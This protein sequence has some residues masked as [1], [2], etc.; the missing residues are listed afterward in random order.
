[1]RFVLPGFVEIQSTSLTS[2]SQLKYVISSASLSSEVGIHSDVWV[3]VEHEESAEPDL[4]LHSYTP[5][6]H[7]FTKEW[8]KL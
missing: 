3:G 2:I 6:R 7:T 8:Q 1:M 4:S 5:S